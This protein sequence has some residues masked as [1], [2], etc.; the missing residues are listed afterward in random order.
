[1]RTD[2]AIEIMP[3][4]PSRAPRITGTVGQLFSDLPATIP[5]C[6]D[7]DIGDVAA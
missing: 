4:A 1:M 3:Q 5:C 2:I 6:I 7:V